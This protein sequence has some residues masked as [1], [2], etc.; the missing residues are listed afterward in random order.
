MTSPKRDRVRS[1]LA[2]L[3]G[4]L[5][6]CAIVAGY[7]LSL[8]WG[9]DACSGQKVQDSIL[10]SGRIGCMEYW[11]ERYQTLIAGILALIAAGIT[12]IFTQRQL[13]EARLVSSLE[14]L[15]HLREEEAT[16]RHLIPTIRENKSYDELRHIAR[17][18]NLSKSGDAEKAMTSFLDSLRD[19][20]REAKGVGWSPDLE[21]WI[22]DRELE[23]TP[24]VMALSGAWSKINVSPR[25]GYTLPEG[26]KDE[27]DRAADSLLEVWKDLPDRLERTADQLEIELD[28][29]VQSRRSLWARVQRA[30][31]A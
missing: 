6:I 5:V 1:H 22:A 20:A 10:A 31:Q 17:V 25:G 19:L 2:A 9:V 29:R 13:R 12:L 8:I 4:G 26:V 14:L 18:K 30:S 3:V 15:R 21:E 16:L 28:V 27:L 7:A 23:S 11:L 24:A